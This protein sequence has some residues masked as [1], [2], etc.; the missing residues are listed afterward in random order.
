[1]SRREDTQRRKVLKKLQEEISKC[2]DPKMVVKLTEQYNALKPKKATSNPEP[3]KKATPESTFV[4]SDYPHKGDFLEKL[5]MGK[6]EFWRVIL[7]VEAAPGFSKM[8]P[9]ERQA[10]AGKMVEGFSDAER[11]ALEAYEPP[12][13]FKS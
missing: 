13:V 8:T 1:M 5:P 2:A 10:L 7:G 3:T 4:K 6:R 12:D 9:D 11:A